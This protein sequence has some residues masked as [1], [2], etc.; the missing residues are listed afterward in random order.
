[1]VYIVVVFYIHVIINL[2]TFHIFSHFQKMFSKH[3]AIKVSKKK[4]TWLE[5]S[6]IIAL[7][8][9]SLEKHCDVIFVIF[10]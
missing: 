6:S 9:L 4:K 8:L 1:M 10:F 7:N 5:I 2:Q 3:G